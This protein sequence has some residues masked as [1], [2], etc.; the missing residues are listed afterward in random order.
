VAQLPV[1][2]THGFAASSASTSVREFLAITKQ[3]AVNFDFAGV[4]WITK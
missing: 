4:G 1:A 3:A 2:A